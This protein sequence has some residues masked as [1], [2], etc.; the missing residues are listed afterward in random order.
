M[1]GYEHSSAGSLYTCDTTDDFGN[2][3]FDTAFS[4]WG[5][6]EDQPSIANKYQQSPIGMLRD[7]ATSSSTMA[8]REHH[9]PALRF[10]A[11]PLR[12][13]LLVGSVKLSI[14]W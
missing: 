14:V 5:Y 13:E 9:T 11:T 1:N 7:S 4:A 6:M 12:F 8:D 3:A 2:E 10:I